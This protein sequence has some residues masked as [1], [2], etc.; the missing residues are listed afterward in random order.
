MVLP[1]IYYLEHLNFAG[2]KL[3][4]M[5]DVMHIIMNFSGSFIAFRIY[6]KFYQFEENLSNI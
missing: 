6:Y 4:L 5:V 2:Y 3:T 1:L